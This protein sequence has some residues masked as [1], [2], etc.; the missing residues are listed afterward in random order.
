VASV[1]SRSR[2]ESW[3][4]SSLAGLGLLS[5]IGLRLL[6]VYWIE[7]ARFLYYKRL[8]GQPESPGRCPG[9]TWSANGRLSQA[10]EA[11]TLVPMSYRGDLTYRL[12]EIPYLLCEQQWTIRQL[13]RHYRVS[14]KTIGRDLTALS[15]F[16]PIVDERRGREVFYGFAKDRGFRSPSFTPA[17]LATLLLAQESIAATGLT[18]LKSPFATH[19]RSLLT[20]VRSALD[21][22]L[23][24]K[25]DAIRDV[26]GT[27]A[28]P[29]KDFSRHSEIIDRL[30][31]AAIRCQRVQ[32]RYYS[33]TK[34]RL[35]SRL[36]D[37]YAV[38]FDPDGAT[39]KMIGYDHKRKIIA[40]FSV[41]HIRRLTD[42]RTTFTRPSDFDLR[43][44]LAKNCFNGIHGEPITVRLRAY[45]V[46]ARVFAERKFHRSQRL[47]QKTP[48][49]STTSETTTIEMRVARGRGLV[50]F[51]L[52]WAPEIQVLSPL[53]VWTEVAT[54]LRNGLDRFQIDHK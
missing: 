13:A 35:A 21:P 28:V 41:D 7:G 11:D 20:K 33:L 47:I 43:E 25:P 8:Y 34:D 50:R 9:S 29:A 22:S 31:T 46:T 49:T 32:L 17:E 5:G 4:L 40:N 3:T 26:V 10:Q 42:T 54:A 18:E 16:H 23:Q 6:F 39:I 12:V 1:H 51:I 36:V 15:R 19:A 52:S 24:S 14:P 44:F 53:S 45:G 27:A 37:P 38:Y 30:T 48:S 2:N